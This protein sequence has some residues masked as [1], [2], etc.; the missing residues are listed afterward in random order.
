[1]LRTFAYLQ[2]VKIIKEARIFIN[3]KKV[4]AL[5]LSPFTFEIFYQKRNFLPLPISKR[6]QDS[7]I[8]VSPA[9]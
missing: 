4:P 1:L 7:S 5:K 3:T 9:K 2:T 6:P 8:P